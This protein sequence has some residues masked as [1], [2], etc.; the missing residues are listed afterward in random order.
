MLPVVDVAAAVVERDGRFLI[1]RRRGVDPDQGGSPGLWEFP[2]GKREAGETL[3]QCL[4][5]EIREELG[6]EIEPGRLI[7]AMEVDTPG[8]TLVLHFFEA[9]LVAG[10]PRPLDCAELAWAAPHALGS[11]DFLPANGD[12]I[13]RLAQER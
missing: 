2:G 4:V 13:R 3:E 7:H 11:Y 8:R 12:L 10:E 1:C 5:R 9:R 6:C